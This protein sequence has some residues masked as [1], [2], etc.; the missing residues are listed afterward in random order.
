MNGKN[1]TL[2][3]YIPGLLGPF[4]HA[5]PEVELGRYPNLQRLLSRGQH[6]EVGA[7]DYVTCVAEHFG[8]LLHEADTPPL[9]AVMRRADGF[10]S[11]EAYYLLAEPVHLRADQGKVYLDAADD[12]AISSEE[13]RELIEACNGLYAED[14]WRIESFHPH[15][16]YLRLPN[17]PRITTAPTAEVLGCAIGDYLPWGD[18]GL[19]WHRV[20]NEIQML[21]HGQAVNQQRAA[22]GEPAINALWLWG[23]GYLPAV[24]SPVPQPLWSDEPW[25]RGLALLSGSRLHTG[26]T[27][28]AGV[29][30]EPEATV[31]FDEL[32]CAM[33]RG[34]T[35]AWLAALER[36]EQAWCAPLVQALGKQRLGQLDIYPGNGMGLRATRKTLRRWWRRGLSYSQLL[37]A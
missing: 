14:G 3:L 28:Y 31:V 29:A 10:A 21:L 9:A 13:A 4:S 36:L 37:S 20:M 26:A 24:D 11:D 8:V 23:G 33:R 22:R 30:G 1:S 12:L 17:A 16:W 15:R 5:T 25:S 27:D 32:A 35:T 19:Y 18:D 34:D 2:T 7:K 6:L